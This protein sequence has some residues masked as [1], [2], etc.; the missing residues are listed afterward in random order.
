MTEI[1]SYAHSDKRGKY[2]KHPVTD[3]VPEYFLHGFVTMVS[4]SQAITMTNVKA[5][6]IEL[7]GFGF[8]I[9]RNIQFLLKVLSHPHVMFA[10]KEMDPYTCICELRYLS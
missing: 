7:K 4:G 8:K 3:R 6:A 9:D 5:F 1:I 2:S 10:N